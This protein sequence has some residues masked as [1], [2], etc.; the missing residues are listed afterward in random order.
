[1]HKKFCLFLLIFFSALLISCQNNSHKDLSGEQLAKN[2]CGSCHLFPSPSLLDS[3]TWKKNILPA[4]GKQ[5]G[6]DYYFEQPFIASGIKRNNSNKISLQQNT[7]TLVDWEKI[8]KYYATNAPTKTPAQ[9]RPP[10]ENFTDRFI[11][12]KMM[13]VIFPLTKRKCA[14]KAQ[15]FHCS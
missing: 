10:L 12:K 13:P 5:L 7:I 6:I 1:M 8:M 3:T 9:N 15:C 11:I 14:V 2:Y 4:M